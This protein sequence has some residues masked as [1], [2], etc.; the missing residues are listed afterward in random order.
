MAMTIEKA[1]EALKEAVLLDNREVRKVW[2]VVLKKGTNKVTYLM[3]GT[4]AELEALHKMIDEHGW[5]STVTPEFVRDAKS[6]E[7]RFMQYLSA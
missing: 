1:M 5:N 2:K 3:H 6:I 7:K 4:Q